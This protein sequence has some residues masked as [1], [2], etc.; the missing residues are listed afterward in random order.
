MCVYVCVYVCVYACVEMRG[1]ESLIFCT[2]WRGQPCAAGVYACVWM[3]V[4]VLNALVC[5]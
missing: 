5:V 3:F 1:C 2:D 4:Y